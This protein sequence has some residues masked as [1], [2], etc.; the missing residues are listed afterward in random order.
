[1]ASSRVPLPKLP[2][3]K[4]IVGSALVAAGLAYALWPE[5]A[6]PKP[7][8]REEVVF[9][10]MWTAEWKGV[11]DRIVARYN[12]S[13]TRYRVVAVSVPSANNQA[14]AKFL[15]AAVG[16]TP[17]DLMAQWLPVVPNWADNGLIR[18]LDELL[19]PEERRLYAHDVYPIVRRMGTYKGRLYGICTGIGMSGLYV[20]ASELRAAGIDPDRPARTLEELDARAARLNRVAK[21]GELRRVGFIPYGLPEY[22]EAFGGGIYDWE[23]G[24]VT[25]DTPA[26]RRALE[27]IVSRHRKLGYDEVV[28]FEA[29]LTGADDAGGWRFIS[30]AYAMTLDGPWRVEQMGRFAPDFDYRTDPLPPPGPSLTKGL[31]NPARIG[32]GVANGNFMLIPSKA[33]HPE[34]AM[35]FARF[36]SGLKDPERAAEFYTWGGWLPLTPRIAAAPAYQAY[37]RKFPRFRTFVDLMPSS[38]LRSRPPVA[39]QEFLASIFARAEEE[40]TR[41]RKTPAQAL[42]DAEKRFVGELKRRKELGYVD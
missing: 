9:W 29:G 5:P 21:G 8:P 24:E 16:S 23:R 40:A 28:R 3:L 1:M 35:D 12:A 20:N 15:L 25:I 33:R 10:H 19:T 14:T 39:Y 13:Q 18:P 17:P 37:L 26:N 38:N 27:Y 31:P 41:G 36:W 7:P 34:G 30:G 32:A 6:P 42:A 2:L 4:R 22:A 11:I